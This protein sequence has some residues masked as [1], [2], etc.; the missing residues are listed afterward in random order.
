MQ[1]IFGQSR[2]IKN[3]ARS[4]PRTAIGTSVPRMSLPINLVTAFSVH[5]LFH[6]TFN[7]ARTTLSFI[8]SPT[9]LFRLG[10]G[11]V[12][13][14]LCLSASS[15]SF[16]VSIFVFA[17]EHRL[18]QSGFAIFRLLRLPVDALIKHNTSAWICLRMT[19]NTTSTRDQTRTSNIKIGHLP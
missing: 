10:W 9:H 5:R 7:C 11:L 16:E 6:L 3:R 17:H 14:F 1:R 8:L 2:A 4:Q 15:S 19:C 12:R 13:C 18:N